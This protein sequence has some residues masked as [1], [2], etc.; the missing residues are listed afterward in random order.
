MGVFSCCS[1]RCKCVS[2]V[3]LVLLCIVS[4]A[5]GAYLYLV[6]YQELN[7][8]SFDGAPYLKEYKYDFSSFVFYIA[9]ASYSTGGVLVF[10]LINA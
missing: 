8:A 5:S 10:G 7:V 2:T 3:L 4:I 1:D 6:A 9:Y